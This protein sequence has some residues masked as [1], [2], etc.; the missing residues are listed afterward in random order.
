MC[1]EDPHAGEQ[2]KSDGKSHWLLTTEVANYVGIGRFTLGLF[3]HVEIV[4]GDGLKRYLYER[5][6]TMSAMQE[7][8]IK[9]R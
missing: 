9:K 4:Q 6:S 2:L 1:E 7:P 5:L 8:Q 3:D